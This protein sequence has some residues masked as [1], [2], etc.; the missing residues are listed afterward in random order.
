MRVS[1][2]TTPSG[3]AH[4]ETEESSDDS[5]VRRAMELD[6]AD[7]EHLA[8]VGLD[9]FPATEQ[10]EDAA[11]KLDEAFWALADAADHWLSEAGH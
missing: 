4:S 8:A 3:N 1:L 6:F 11:S 7:L 10:K 9:A 5:E 2:A